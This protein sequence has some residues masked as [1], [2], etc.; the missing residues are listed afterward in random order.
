MN[1]VPPALT[2]IS[3]PAAA[4]TDPLVARLRADAVASVGGGVALVGGGVAI[5]VVTVGVIVLLLDL[6]VGLPGLTYSAWFVILGV[7]Y[8]AGAFAW[9]RVR[10]KRFAR[11]AFEY[12][13]P[14]QEWAGVGRYGDANGVGVAGLAFVALDGFFF[15]PR[16]LMS[17]VHQSAGR[18]PA[19][20]ERF[21]DRCALLL[22][23]LAKAGEQVPA[24]T[25]SI[26]DD[27]TPA[28]L[29]PVL[30]YLDRAGWTGASSDASRLWL[31][32]RAKVDLVR[33]GVPVGPAIE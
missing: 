17:G 32:S 4:P 18:E 6:I 31:S 26:G 29:A 5:S 14:R 24:S 11:G 25:V 33:L 20:R 3:T 16:M 21:F 30:N 7:V 12:V 9:L 19:S 8:A 15:G 23:Q 2:P 28:K 22:R 13:D 10:E 1:T 27:E